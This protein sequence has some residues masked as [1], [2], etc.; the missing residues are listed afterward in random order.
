M[1]SNQTRESLV[2]LLELEGKSS[3][4]LVLVVVV[5]SLNHQKPWF[6]VVTG[7][8]EDQSQVTFSFTVLVR[9]LSVCDNFENST[10]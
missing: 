8:E 5:V 10:F 4:S 7:G 1:A 2:Y 9:T 3:K 6:C